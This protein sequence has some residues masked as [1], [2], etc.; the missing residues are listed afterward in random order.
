VL[1]SKTIGRLES[2]DATAV[3]TALVIEDKTAT[4]PVMRGV[5]IDL[6]HAVADAGCDWK[7][8]AWNILCQRP[9]AAVYVEEARLAAVRDG[10]ARGAAELL[11]S[12]YRGRDALGRESSGVLVCG[13]QFSGRQPREVAAL[14]TQAIEALR[15]AR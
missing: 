15:A 12:Q 7:Y 5:R 6:T 8:K 10:V 4:S 2:L 14:L 13:Y 3:V 11:I 1:W 9:G